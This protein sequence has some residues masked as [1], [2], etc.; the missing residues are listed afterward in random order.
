VE[1]QFFEVKTK[2]KSSQARVGEIK[3]SRGT[4]ETPCFIP[5]ATYGAVK[6][7]TAE[8]LGQVGLQMILGN[9][10]HL[11]I[12]PGTETIKK[13]GGLHQLMNW[14]GPILTDS[15][16]WQVF[17]LIYQ[18]GMGKIKKDGIEY[19]DHLTGQ[20][21]WLTP[22]KCLE[23]QLN[24]GS[25][26]LMILDYPVAAKAEENENRYSV[27]T[28]VR[29][30]KKAKIFYDQH[31]KMKE[32]MMMAIIQ[33]A[34]SKE[35][36]KECFAELESLWPWPGYGFGGPTVNDE[37][38]EYTASLIPQNR[39]RYLMGAG[40]PEQIVRAVDQGWDLFDCVIPTRN[41]RH[42]MA[43]TFSGSVKI[44]QK[45]YELDDSP[46]E[47]DCPCL[48]CQGYTRA[49]IRHLLKIDEPVGKRLMTIH[50][51]TFYMRLMRKIRQDI[52]SG[53]FQPDRLLDQL[54]NSGN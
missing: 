17:S 3:T 2:D 27:S 19:K 7:L 38:I 4:I 16:G 51:L 53:Q 20:K 24:I 11:R 9:I 40:P 37:I 14:N 33:G 13:L 5:D 44:Y 48:A 47:K 41:A 10:Y 31:P 32:K 26:I 49:Y 50:N 35:L 52:K 42:G 46:I 18:Y 36:R 12:R 54:E 45:Q 39:L 8:D 43:Y 23:D 1:N 34:N 6:H 28:T 21:H 29:W 15:G 25:D 30:A 22:E